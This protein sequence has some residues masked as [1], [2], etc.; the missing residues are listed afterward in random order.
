[1]SCSGSGTLRT[2]QGK[3]SNNIKSVQFM[4]LLNQYGMLSLDIPVE[5]LGA[6]GDNAPIAFLSSKRLSPNLAMPGALEGEN[7]MHSGQLR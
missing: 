2:S 3:H 6:H 5:N 7:D 1:M 4:R